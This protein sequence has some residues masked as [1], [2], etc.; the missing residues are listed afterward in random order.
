MRKKKMIF[1]GTWSNLAGRHFRWVQ[2]DNGGLNPIGTAS[3]HQLLIHHG[4]L[5]IAGAV[6]VYHGHPGLVGT[7][8]PGL[9]YLVCYQLLQYEGW[10]IFVVLGR[11][12]G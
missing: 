2:L 11:D 8:H 1:Y 9:H 4:G 5:A 12:I 10:Y 6:E 7:D 3:V